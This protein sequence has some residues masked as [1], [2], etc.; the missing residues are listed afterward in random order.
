MIK[1]FVF[2]FLTVFT[3][4]NAQ[5]RQIEFEHGDF[6][7]VKARAKKE[8]KNIFVD[9]YTS[10]CGPCKWMAKNIFT[11]DTA[12]DHFNK[13][14]V[15]YKLD[16]EKGEGLEF[17][18]T[19][20]VQ[21]YPTLIILD[22]EGK[23]IHRTAGGLP[24][25]EFIAFAD[26]S[27]TN[28]SFSAIVETY[29]K[30]KKNGIALADYANAMASTC[31]NA[32]IE[33]QTYIQSLPEKDLEKKENWPLLR[34]YISDFNSREIKYFMKNYAAFEKQF[35]K[36]E[37]EPKVI[38]AGV[39]YF[40]PMMSSAAY[41]EDTYNKFKQEFIAMKWPNTERIIFEADMKIYAAVN[42]QKY[43]AVA[44]KDYLKYHNDEANYLNGM[45]WTLYK[46][47][48]VKEELIA[49]VKMS[50][51]ACEL[52]PSYA[53]YDTQAAIQ[54]KSGDLKG[55]Q[56]TAT[57]AIELAKK[58]KKEEKDYQATTD[59]LTKIKAEIK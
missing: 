47:T 20:T 36:K 23:L 59:L 7:S 52:D 10:W 16:M 27:K 53:N 30:D 35:G 8:N 5:N 25:K 12:A 9:A 26:A 4:S 11:N 40:M 50:Q 1:F 17:A 15:C 42:I 56:Q 13:N 51:R 28:R 6:A 55:A 2:T 46:N 41:S 39:T 32:A 57:R 29:N 44:A 38:Q 3:L 19:Y 49:G 54:Y 58:E 37:T 48:N 24:V 43:Y 14:F 33:V 34:D 31:L 45:A 22:A 21:C 18:K